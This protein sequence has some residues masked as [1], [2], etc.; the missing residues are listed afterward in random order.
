MTKVKLLRPHLQCHFLRGTV[1]HTQI[2]LCEPFCTLITPEAK[3]AIRLTVSVLTK[4]PSPWSRFTIVRRVSARSILVL[5]VPFRV[6]M[7]E[8]LWMDSHGV[9]IDDI[10]WV[11]IDDLKYAKAE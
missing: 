3:T 4:E 7:Q 11:K 6:C 10:L 1:E 5:G 2:A 9:G 8:A